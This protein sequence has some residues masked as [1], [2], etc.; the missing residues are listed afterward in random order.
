MRANARRRILRPLYLLTKPLTRCGR[1]GADLLVHESTWSADLDPQLIGTAG[2]STA[3][4]AGRN[5]AAAGVARLALTHISHRYASR[6]S[7]LLDE[8][9][10]E[11]A[12]PVCIP[13]SR[14][15]LTV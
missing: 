6:E 1:R 15:V 2:H 14:T 5:A 10:R 4:E 9:R 8:A 12:G 11:F 13:T 3:Q 7:T